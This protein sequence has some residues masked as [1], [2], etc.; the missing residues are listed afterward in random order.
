MVSADAMIHTLGKIHV[1]IAQQPQQQQ[2][3]QNQHPRLY[4]I[5]NIKRNWER[6]GVLD[7]SSSSSTRDDDDDDDDDDHQE[8]KAEGH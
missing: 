6:K 8:E 3:Q 1:S 7:G 5:S 4:F 2:K